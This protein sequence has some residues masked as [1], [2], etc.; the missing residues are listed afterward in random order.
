MKRDDDAF[1]PQTDKE[2]LLTVVDPWQ[3][4]KARPQ[5]P[6]PETL[7]SVWW[8]VLGAIAL[9]GIVLAWRWWRA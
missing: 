5:P 7:S 6:P 3:E 1:R 2:R 9:V 8:N 4:R